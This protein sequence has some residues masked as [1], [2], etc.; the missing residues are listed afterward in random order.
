MHRYLPL[1]LLAA[2][3]ATPDAAAQHRIRLDLE[4]GRQPPPPPPPPPRPILQIVQHVHQIHL[5]G[6]GSPL[7][8]IH[9]PIVTAGYANGN[10]NGKGRG[11]PAP[12][13]GPRGANGNGLEGHYW[14]S[15]HNYHAPSAHFHLPSLGLPVPQVLPPP[16]T[17]AAPA[18]YAAPAGYANGNGLAPY[19]APGSYYPN[20]NG[21]RA[22]PAPS[23]YPRNY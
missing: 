8:V 10:G 2:L 23:Y 12:P 17:Q 22:A 5:P 15:V 21:Y 19:A 1:A 9:P 11:A 3:L 20:G 16:A 13:A 6:G 18:Y 4:I 14:P 7:T